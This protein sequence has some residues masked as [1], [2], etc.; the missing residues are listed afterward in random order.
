M[1][2]APQQNISLCTMQISRFVYFLP[3]DNT[4]VRPLPQSDIAF[5]PKGIK[6]SR[7]TFSRVLLLAARIIQVTRVPAKAN[8][9][10]LDLP[11]LRRY[12]E[13]SIK[14]KKKL[15]NILSAKIP[16]YATEDTNLVVFGS[17]ARGEW[18]SKS[19]LDWTYLIDGEVNADHLRI[20]QRINTILGEKKFVDPGPTGTFGNMAFSHEIVHQIGGQS[21]T[22]KNTT[23]RVLL[24]LE[25]CFIGKRGEAHERIIR[26]IINRYLEEDDHH[27][28]SDSKRYRVPRFL[29]NDLVRFWRTMAVDFASKQRDRGGKGWGLRNAKLRMSRKLIFA[30]GLAICFGVTLDPKLNCHIS[31][32]KDDIKL[33][34]INHIRERIRFTPLEVLSNFMKQYEVP[35]RIAKKLFHSYAEFLDLLDDKKSREA[36]N[37]LRAADSRSD[38][39]FKK[40]RKIGEV[41]QH[42]LDYI[43][44]EN[45]KI[46]PLTRKYGVF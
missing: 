14:I 27:L 40:V 15:E 43:F 5:N 8:A 38:P 25:S 20:S 31:T 32:D 19:D 30:S 35:D 3:I 41:F 7:S 24:L 29:L 2:H 39:T 11:S 21:D 37:V 13:D 6:G 10:L 26:A 12:R 9:N 18:T 22:N 44:F 45:P 28:M 46:A 36:L 34:L 16:S 33:N 17:L 1:G 23:Q 42:S 4:F